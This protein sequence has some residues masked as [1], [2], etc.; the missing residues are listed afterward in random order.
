MVRSTRYVLGVEL[1]EET[2]LGGEPRAQIDTL[3]MGVEL[4][5]SEIA[6]AAKSTND[7]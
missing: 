1:V 6:G 3:R 2:R 7:A 4:V 5:M